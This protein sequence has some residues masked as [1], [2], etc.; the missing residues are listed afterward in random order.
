M[1]CTHTRHKINKNVRINVLIFKLQECEAE[2]VRDQAFI[3]RGLRCTNENVIVYD[4]R[5]HVC[6]ILM[7][8]FFIF[9]YEYF[10]GCVFFG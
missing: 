2:R 10:D 5:A 8:T 3:E 6:C 9:I 7:G 4:V 1:T